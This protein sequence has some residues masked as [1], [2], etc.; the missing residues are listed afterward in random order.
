MDS[1]QFESWR[2]VRDAIRRDEPIS[3]E[4]L[5]VGR[6]YLARG[7]AIWRAIVPAAAV[8]LIVVNIVL[9]ISRGTATTEF[10][11]VELVLIAGCAVSTW[12]WL[13]LR[14]WARRHPL[15]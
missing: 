5:D 9:R 15:P 10:I 6:A 1:A 3:P 4:D 14:R 11:A 8:V 7:T 13:K 2:R 12:P